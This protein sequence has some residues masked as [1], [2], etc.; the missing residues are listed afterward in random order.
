MKSILELSDL[1]SIY[2]RPNQA[3]IK[4]FFYW[5]PICPSEKLSELCGFLIGDGHIQGAPHWRIDFT[6]NNLKTL[7]YVNFLFYDL[8]EVKGKVRGCTTNKY[9]TMNLGINCKPL[10]RI[11][12]LCGVPI[13]A[14]V[15]TDF[16]IP[17]WVT[18]N[19]TIFRAFIR[20]YF[21]CEACVDKTGKIMLEQWKTV[22][23]LGVAKQFMLQIIVGLNRHFL[24][25]PTSNVA[26]K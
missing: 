10:A 2:A 15:D 19:P 16:I 9:G 1:L 4:D 13:G 18:E 26:T 23:K 17:K 25:W 24:F 22:E 14:K 20:A 12:F 5:F 3:H 11:L 7:T 8:F 6:S 21:S